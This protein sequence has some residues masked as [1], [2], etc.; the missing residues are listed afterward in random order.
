MNSVGQKYSANRLSSLDM[1][2]GLTVIGMIIVDP[3]GALSPEWTNTAN[4]FAQLCHSRWAGLTIADV[5]FPAF[6]IM[7]GVSVPLAARSTPDEPLSVM[8]R[9]ISARAARLA[10]VGFVLMNLAWFQDFSSGDWR[11]LGALQRIALVYAA[12]AF[13]AM[14]LPPRARAVLIV[15]ILALYWPLALLQPLDG[16]ALDLMVR[17]QNFISSV[18]RVLLA[19]HIYVHGPDGFDPV[20]AGALL[21]DAD[22]DQ[23]EAKSPA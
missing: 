22:P 14:L 20:A 8:G 19:P 13:L 4:V 18:D 5:M 23:S 10:I 1:L 7:V 21:R 11:L 16:G 15:A 12:S 17:G 6:L 3:M 9:K 2:R